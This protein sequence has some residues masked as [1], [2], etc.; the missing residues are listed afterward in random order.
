VTPPPERGRPDIAVEVEGPDAKNVDELASFAINIINTGT[1]PLTNVTIV[2]D[3]DRELDPESATSGHKTDAADRL[4]WSFSRLEAGKR[5]LLEAVCRCKAESNRACISVL[6]T[7]AERAEDTGEACVQIG[8]TATDLAV[9]VIEF[10]DPVTVGKEADYEIRVKNVGRTIDRQ[11]VVEF[12]LP[13]G[14]AIVPKGTIGAAGVVRF[15]QVGG[16]TYR[17]DPPV[18]ELRPNE[19]LT[20]RVRALAEKAGDGAFRV[21]V[22][23]QGLE[24]PA[25]DEEQVKILAP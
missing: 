2:A 9:T 16:S 8:S 10:N 19:S 15:T 25:R 14:M 23:S 24:Q 6:A 3:F 21:K 13:G 11:V 5:L 20:F 4:T 7:S 22:D 17:F 18:A 1:T 12:T